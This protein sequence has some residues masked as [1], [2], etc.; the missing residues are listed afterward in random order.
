VRVIRRWHWAPLVLALCTLACSGAGGESPEPDQAEFC[1]HLEAAADLTFAFD[2]LDLGALE[3]L[4][5]ELEA[6]VAVAPLDVRDD[7]GVIAHYARGVLDRWQAA[8]PLDVPAARAAFQ[9]LDDDRARVEAA[10]TALEEYARDHCD[11]DLRHPPAP[12]TSG[13]TV[14]PTTAEPTL[15][16]PPTSAAVTT[17]PVT[18]APVTT[19][20]PAPTASLPPNANTTT[21]QGVLTG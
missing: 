4:V 17:A 10:G 7:T 20:S 5:P 2:Q 19:W 3:S 16:A 15:T 21:T 9:A 8:E 12:P 1:T 11:L 13:T 14:P 6:A 18:T